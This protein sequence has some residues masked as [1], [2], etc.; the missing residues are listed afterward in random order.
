MRAVLVMI[1]RVGLDDVVKLPQAEAEQQVQARRPSVSIVAYIRD[2][3]KQYQAAE[4]MPDWNG[5]D[6]MLAEV[7]EQIKQ[8]SA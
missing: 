5:L 4:E 7:R 1:L 2:V 3:R 6:G 8:A